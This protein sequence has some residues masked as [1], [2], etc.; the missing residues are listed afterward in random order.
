MAGEAAGDPESERTRERELARSCAAGDVAAQ[1]ELVRRFSALVWSLCLRA[2]L[3]DAEAQ[4]VSQEV[5]WRVFQALPGFR[6][7]SRLST[8]ISTVA[9]RRIVDHRR[10]R[11]RRDVAVGAPSDPGFPLPA[12][13]AS[14]SPENDANLSQRRQRV[15]AALDHLA[16]PAR[17]VLVAYYL[18]E[19]PVMVIARI[20]R[21][22]EGTVKTHLHRGRQTL[23]NHL[24]DLC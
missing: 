2:G 21:M 20:L 13:P 1:H 22:P 7:E 10:S 8:W 5:F 11:A 19:M 12:Q 23:R 17:S 9:L 15:H 3:P 24:R 4:D 16:E 14:S 6:G 18:G